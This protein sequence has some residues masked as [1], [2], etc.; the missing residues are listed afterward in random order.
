LTSG[1]AGDTWILSALVSQEGYPAEAHDGLISCL[2]ARWNDGKHMEIITAMF[3][4]ADDSGCVSKH[5]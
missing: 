2:Q 1:F 3:R 4:K 5:R